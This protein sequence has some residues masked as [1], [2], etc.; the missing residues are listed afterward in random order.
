MFVP[1]RKNVWASTA[2]YRDDFTVYILILMLRQHACLG[3]HDR[4]RCP[5]PEIHDSMRMRHTQLDLLSFQT[6]SLCSAGK[7]LA[8]R[9]GHADSRK[10]SRSGR[11]LECSETRTSS[12][13]GDFSDG[14]TVKERSMRPTF[15]LLWAA[16][17]VPVSCVVQLSRY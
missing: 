15:C 2:C 3:C 4:F 1:H 14:V 6:I 17:T 7:L 8:N 11:R 9:V 16:E 13:P 12:H 10:R 5:G